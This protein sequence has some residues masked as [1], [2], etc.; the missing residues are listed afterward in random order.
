MGLIWTL[1]QHYQMQSAAMKGS[2]CH[3][4]H[5]FVA[6]IVNSEAIVDHSDDVYLPMGLF[7]QKQP[8]DQRRDQRKVYC[9]G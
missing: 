8:L 9:Y 7:K 6:F 2:F 5:R 3:P 4:L 1:I